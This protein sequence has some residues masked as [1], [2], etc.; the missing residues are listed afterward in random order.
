MK[1][2]FLKELNCLNISLSKSRKEE[3]YQYW[4]QLQKQF[5]LKY[6]TVLISLL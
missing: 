5:I 1:Q 2:A 4:L 3:L 6:L